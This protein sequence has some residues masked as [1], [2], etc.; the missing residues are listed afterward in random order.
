MN[1]LGE[2]DGVFTRNDV[3]RLRHGCRV[4]LEQ[5]CASQR[6]R[7]RRADLGFLRNRAK[8]R[9]RASLRERS[10]SEPVGQGLGFGFSRSIPMWNFAK[11]FPVKQSSKTNHSIEGL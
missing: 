7:T 10:A 3:L 11:L 5:L 8:K 1:R 2:V 4:V 6:G 9:E